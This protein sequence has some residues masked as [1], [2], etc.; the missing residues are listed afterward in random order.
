MY[1]HQMSFHSN[2]HRVPKKINPQFGTG[3]TT[4]GYEKEPSLKSTVSANSTSLQ[5]AKDVVSKMWKAVSTWQETDDR[6]DR[7]QKR[8]EKSEKRYAAIKRVKQR[9]QDKLQ[10]PH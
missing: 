1:V 7:N 4:D 5:N 10:S 2:V 3:N 6:A 9:A 8:L